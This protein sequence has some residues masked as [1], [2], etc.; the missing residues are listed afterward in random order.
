M[1]IPRP[2][3]KDTA[4]SEKEGYGPLDP[5]L[6][7][8]RSKCLQEWKYI[9]REARFLLKKPF[10]LD[11]NRALSRCL[12]RC[13]SRI[14]FA[15]TS[16]CI[17][18]DFVY[19]MQQAQSEHFNLGEERQRNCS[20]LYFLVCVVVFVCFLTLFSY[21]LDCYFL[22]VFF[23]FFSSFI[24]LGAKMRQCYLLSINIYK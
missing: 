9:Y 11:E 20:K 17:S 21:S 12:S 13:Q 14:C 6:C 3:Q 7:I 22:F 4:F 23:S 24:A 15:V 8:R 19:L 5:V 16:K 18:K 1:Q 2:W 10:L